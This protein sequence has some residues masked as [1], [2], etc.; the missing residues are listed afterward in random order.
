MLIL[1]Q[2]IEQSSFAVSDDIL[3]H[4]QK[5]QCKHFSNWLLKKSYW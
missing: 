4:K 5:G 1:S 2:L 3:P